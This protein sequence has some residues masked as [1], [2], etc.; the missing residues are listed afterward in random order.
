MKKVTLLIILLLIFSNCVGER[1]GGFFGRGVDIATDPRT[2]GT[3]IDDSIM[4][5]NLLT[6]LILANKKY[7]LNIKMRL[8]WNISIINLVPI[9]PNGIKGNMNLYP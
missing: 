6:R 5:K 7:F 4:Q 3:Q 1:S 8:F 2:L 9:S